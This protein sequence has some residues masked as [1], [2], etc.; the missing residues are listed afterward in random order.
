MFICSNCREEVLFWKSAVDVEQKKVQNVFSCPYCKVR[1]SK[2]NLE[3]VW[4]QDKK[5]AKQVPVLINYSVGTKRFEKE[6][7]L[8]DLDLIQ[9]IESTNIPHWYPMDELHSGFS[10]KQPKAS[11]GISRVDLFYY[12]RSLL[13]L[14][15]LRQGIDKT[16]SPIFRKLLFVFTSILEGSSKLNRERPGGMP[17]KLNGT[18]YVGSL[19]REINVLDF[20]RRKA[21]KICEINIES[22]NFISTSSC[23]DLNFLPD[24]SIDYIFTDPPF[25]GNIMYS[26]L[27]F[28][29]EAW[30]RI[31]TNNQQEAVINK[32]QGKTFRTYRALME[33][34]FKEFYRVLK[35]G[36]WFTLVFHNSNNRVWNIIQNALLGAG[37]VVE[38]IRSLD[39]RQG[40]FKQVTTASIKQDL[41]VS[42]YKKIKPGDSAASLQPGTEKGVWDFV[43]S[44]LEMLPLPVFNGSRPETIPERKKHQLYDSMVAFHVR[45]RLTVPLNIQEFYQGLQER[46]VEKN[47]MYF[48]P[49]QIV[50]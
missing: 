45:N 33:Q 6:P 28:I 48:L 35:G 29:W 10:F 22:N 9:E 32:A 24:E 11:H 12:K 23:T 14:S 49:G 25:G 42:A 31:K 2:K 47:T 20:F 3:R 39:K 37:F 16:D 1:L 36:R 44:R 41:V 8:L 30:L 26:E 19:V 17:S 4:V 43:Q 50:E 7:D 40:S 15:F 13:I 34:S 27:N 18:L 21:A 5:I 38:D 46:F